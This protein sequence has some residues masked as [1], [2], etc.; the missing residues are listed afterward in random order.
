MAP[1]PVHRARL[2]EMFWDV[3][4]DPRGELRWCLSK[5]RGLVGDPSH[6]RVKAENDLVSID[7]STID[8]DALCVAA[9]AEGAISG[10]D[11]DLL[12][13]LATKFG[14]EFL[15]GFDADRVPLFEAWPIG[16]RQRFH[17]LHA[18]ILSRIMALLP[19]AGEALPY[20]R[21]RLDLAPYDVAA[22]RDLLATLAACGRFAE[23]EAHLV[24]ATH[25]FTSQDLS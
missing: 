13:Q 19:N 16:E 18:D 24:A 23:G 10:G 9:R 11:L 25:L 8:V 4:N 1:R 17:D 2:C 14:G 22:H 21:K 7:T 20:A 12:K 15:E 6:E 3:P 5:I